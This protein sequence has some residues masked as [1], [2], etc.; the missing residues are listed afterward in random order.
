VPVGIF[1]SQPSTR[2]ML[3]G[4]LNECYSVAIA[5]GIRLPADSVANTLAYIDSLAPGTMASMQRDIMEGRPSELEAQNGDIVHMGRM[6][7]IPTSVHSFIYHSL[8][9]QE[10]LT[11][12]PL[13]YG[14]SVVNRTSTHP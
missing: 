8:L 2:Q 12:S 6:N 7:N 10:N 4:A 14:F 5:Q 9:P 11:R 3:E 13:D 1:R